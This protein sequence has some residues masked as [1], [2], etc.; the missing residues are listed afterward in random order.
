LQIEQI[1]EKLSRALRDDDGV[2]FGDALE[3]RR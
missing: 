3:A 2:W 1:A